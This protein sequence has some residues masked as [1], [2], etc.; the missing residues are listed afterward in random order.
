MSLV[1]FV[2]ASASMVV[3]FGCRKSRPSVG[4][5]CDGIAQPVCVDST[6]ALACRNARYES[7]VCKGPDGCVN[8]AYTSLARCDQTIADEGDPCPIG[9]KVVAC[10]SKGATLLQ[11]GPGGRFVQVMQCRGPDGCQSQTFEGNRIALC[12]SSVANE[13]DACLDI[14][15]LNACTL[16]HQTLLSCSGGTFGVLSECTR[17]HH[18]DI[19]APVRCDGER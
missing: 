11:C 14:S 15:P 6:H 19:H 1:V 13:G 4:D 3:V 7:V 18:C 2:V 10:A 12:D 9:W 17:P 5:S 8:E 16:D